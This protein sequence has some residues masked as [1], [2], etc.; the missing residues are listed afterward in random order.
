MLLL[1]ADFIICFFF[2][3][4]SLGTLYKSVKQFGH[5]SGPMFCLSYFG[6]KLSV[7][8]IIRRQ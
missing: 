3:K 8:V 4:K 5:R 1:S 7:K 2:L 6:S